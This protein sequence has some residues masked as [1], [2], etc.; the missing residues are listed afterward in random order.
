M[1]PFCSGRTRS[2]NRGVY[3]CSVLLGDFSR[4]LIPLIGV[5]IIRGYNVCAAVLLIKAKFYIFGILVRNILNYS[6]KNKCVECRTK[7]VMNY[8]AWQHQ[9]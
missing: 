6:N 3:M 7:R 8:S 1:V 4:E 5:S 2:K 9:V